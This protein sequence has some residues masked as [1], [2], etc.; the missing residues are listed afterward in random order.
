[1]WSARLLNSSAKIDHRTYASVRAHKAGQITCEGDTVSLY[2]RSSWR[3]GTE[4]A[5]RGGL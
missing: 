5:K 3:V 1:M 2:Q 4:V